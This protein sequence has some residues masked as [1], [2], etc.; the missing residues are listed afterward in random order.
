MLLVIALYHNWTIRQLDVVAAYL[1][2]PLYHEVYVLRTLTRTLDRDLVLRDRVVLGIGTSV[3][4]E[5]GPRV[6][7][8]R[9][10]EL[11]V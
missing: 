5:E 10:F 8:S 1:Q 7:Y 3:R 2:A 6:A 9:V 11:R 4:S